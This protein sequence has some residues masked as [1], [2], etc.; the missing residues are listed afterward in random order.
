MNLFSTLLRWKFHVNNGTDVRRFIVFVASVTSIEL[1]T[2]LKF[3]F[4]CYLASNCPIILNFTGMVEWPIKSL[5]VNFQIILRCFIFSLNSKILLKLYYS[6]VLHPYLV[7]LYQRFLKIR[8]LKLKMD[9]LLDFKQ[10][11]IWYCSR[12]TK[13]WIELK[14]CNHFTWLFFFCVLLYHL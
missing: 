8:I 13:F 4:L 11:N 10:I 12:C 1:Y 9:Q 14:I 7:L 2:G 6:L 3:L 5:H